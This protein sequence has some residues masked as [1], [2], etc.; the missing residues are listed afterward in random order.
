MSTSLP[1]EYVVHSGYLIK[2]GK[3][4]KSWKVRFF[5]LRNDRLQY[6]KDFLTFYRQRKPRG[7][8]Y[9]RDVGEGI[10]TEFEEKADMRRPNLFCIDMLY[11]RFFICAHSGGDMLAWV[12]KLREVVS[13][14]E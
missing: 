14:I 2:R 7:E 8:M 10:L 13:R 3:V 5:V 1:A 12:N 11:R 9:L 4:R 6:Y